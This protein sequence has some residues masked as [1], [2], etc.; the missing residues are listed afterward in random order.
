[1]TLL[2]AAHLGGDGFVTFLYGLQRVG[3]I[4]RAELRGWLGLHGAVIR[5]V[6]PPLDTGDGVAPGV[7]AW[8]LKDMAE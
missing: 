7:V 6:E 4:D 3:V 5:A 1:M 2:R 8:L